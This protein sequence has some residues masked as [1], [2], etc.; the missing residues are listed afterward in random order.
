MSKL[1]RIVAL[2]ENSEPLSA[3]NL[4]LT[5][6]EENI[7][8]FTQP[9][10]LWH[11]LLSHFVRIKL[12][13]TLMFLCCWQFPSLE[14]RV[15]QGTVQLDRVHCLLDVPEGGHTGSGY[16]R[17]P[18]LSQKALTPGTRKSV[19]VRPDKPSERRGLCSSRHWE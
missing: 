18:A 17:T 14:L 12:L 3:A 10:F 7:Q 13:C 4:W 2:S 1:W 19:C 11:L 5:H 15:A 8:P 6:P 9:S 16:E